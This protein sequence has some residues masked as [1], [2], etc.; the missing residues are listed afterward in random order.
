ME[1]P[2]VAHVYGIRAHGQIL[3]LVFFMDTIGGA[4]GPF[5][6]GYIFDTAGVY[7]QAFIVCIILNVLCL[8]SIALLKRV[9]NKAAESAA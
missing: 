2:V 5:L 7:S 6:T 8:I 3:G 1:S 9:A 4:L